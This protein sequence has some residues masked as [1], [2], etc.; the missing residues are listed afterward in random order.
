VTDLLDP[1]AGLS[2]EPPSP[3]GR[4]P[5]REGSPIDAPVTGRP[6]RRAAALL[7]LSWVPLAASLLAIVLSLSSL[8]VSTREP[9]VLVILPD[10]VRLV[11]GRA[12]GASYAYLQPAFVST[13]VNDRVEVIRDMRLLAR[14][15]DGGDPV[16]LEWRQQVTLVTDDQ[17]VLSYRYLADAVPLLVAAR[18]AAAPLSLFQGPQGWHLASGTYR[19]TLEADRFAVSEPLRASFDVTLGP[20]EM[21]ILDAPGPERFLAFTVEQ[22]R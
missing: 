13:G 18:S 11:G 7:P 9:E 17:G 10:I 14:R 6:W 16:E 3:A 4:S 8:W 15:A 2:T 22:V 21:E 19:F 1:L 12:S 20:D 5:A